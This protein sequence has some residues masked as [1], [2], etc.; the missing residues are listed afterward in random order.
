[1]NLNDLTSKEQTE[2]AINLAYIGD[3]DE[4]I[5]RLRE[6]AAAAHRQRLF[7]DETNMIRMIKVL[8]EVPRQD[9]TDFMIMAKEQIR[10]IKDSDGKVTDIT[11]SKD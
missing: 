9:L 8:T 4:T 5:I 7:K 10:F 2:V 11:N 1:M 6:S 3:I